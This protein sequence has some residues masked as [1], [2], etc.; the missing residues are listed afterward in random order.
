VVVVVVVVVVD[1]AVDVVGVVVDPVFVVVD[2]VVTDEVVVPVGSVP[3]WS[4]VPVVPPLSLTLGAP[5]RDFSRSAVRAA[6]PELMWPN[7]WAA[8]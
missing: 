6:R 2:P 1:W 3:V 5:P 4:V 8:P 7:C